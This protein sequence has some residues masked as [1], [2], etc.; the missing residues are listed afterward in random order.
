MTHPDV[1]PCVTLETIEAAAV[2]IAP[3]IRR[4]PMIEVGEVRDWP[5]ANPVFLKL[6]CLQVTGAFKARGAVNRLLT[7]PKER[8]ARGIVTASGGNHGMAVARAGFLAGVPTTVYLPPNASRAKIDALAGWNAAVHVVGETWDDADRIAQGHADRGGAVY[9]HPF[10]DPE[11][12]AGQGTVALE[13]LAA[14]PDLDVYLVAIGGG[15]LIAGLSTVIHAVNPKARIVGIEP[16]GAPTLH[17]A[18]AAGGPVRLD[19]VT[20]RVATMS[21][22]L[23]VPLIYD[24]VARHVEEVVLVEDEELIA[25]ARWFRSEF[26]IRAD[27]SAVAG[28]AALRTGRIRLAAHERVGTLICGADDAALP[29]DS[30]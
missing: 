10:K 12:V 20:T 17:A 24:I 23:T 8:L 7:T 11:V 15:G 5:V 28:L 21:C 2:R 3:H 1:L 14:M 6:E 19:R 4:T 25:A 16:T 9:F 22:G 26:G 27:L 13:M 30:G 18:L 29:A